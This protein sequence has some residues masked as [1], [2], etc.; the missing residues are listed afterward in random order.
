M[1]ERAARDWAAA[2]PWVENCAYEQP[3]DGKTCA[4]RRPRSAAVGCGASRTDLPSVASA[5]GA[6][7]T[8]RT[9][10]IEDRMFVGRQRAA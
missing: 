4:A 7:R 3:P 8:H 6:P 1:L 5:L 10:R 9:K 2:P